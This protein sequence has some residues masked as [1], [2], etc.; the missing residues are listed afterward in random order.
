MIMPLFLFSFLSV[1]LLVFLL[2][3]MMMMM[4]LLLLQLLFSFPKKNTKVPAYLWPAAATARFT[5]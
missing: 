3:L 4:F 1:F 2:L 5:T